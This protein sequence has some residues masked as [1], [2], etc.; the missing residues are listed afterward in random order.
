MVTVSTYSGTGEGEWWG[1]GKEGWG[2]R[3]VGRKETSEE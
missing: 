1:L 2:A 3:R